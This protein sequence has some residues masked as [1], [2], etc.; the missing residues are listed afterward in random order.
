[1]ALLILVSINIITRFFL[2]QD[3]LEILR[4]KELN[5]QSDSTF[6]SSHFNASNVEI[7]SVVLNV[8]S[9]YL[10]KSY[11]ASSGFKV[12]LALNKNYM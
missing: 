2:Q 10:A 1:M 12:I 5:S 7:A 11:Y 4:N 8:S 3:E 9:T 6:D